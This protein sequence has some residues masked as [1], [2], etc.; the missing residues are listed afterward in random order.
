M[1]DKVTLSVAGIIC[2]TL[3]ELSALEHGIDGQ[4]MLGVII[5]ISAAIG[6]PVG[7]IIKEQVERRRR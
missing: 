2:L 3:I 6:L 7:G 5:A 1:K 4:L